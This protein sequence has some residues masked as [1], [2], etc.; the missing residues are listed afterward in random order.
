MATVERF[1]SMTCLRIPILLSLLTLI[2]LITTPST[3][4]IPP[5]ILHAQ[6]LR[7][8]L[9]SL[10]ALCNN[11]ERWNQLLTD[12]SATPH[13]QIIIVP[14]AVDS[15][16][17]PGHLLYLYDLEAIPIIPFTGIGNARGIP[18]LHLQPPLTHHRIIINREELTAYRR[19]A[20][21]GDTNGE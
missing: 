16:S 17:R 18:H 3:P 11:P 9:R 2:P 15:T 21:H 1:N 14:C 13:S 8:H 10:R 5:S 7:N 19:L 20:P 6:S 4:E 12:L